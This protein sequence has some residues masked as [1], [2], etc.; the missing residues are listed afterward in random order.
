MKIIVAD[1]GPLIIFAKTIGL[2]I[3]KSVAHE[4][5]VPA[6][7]AAE[8]T[9]DMKKEGALR[10]ATAIREGLLTVVDDPDV[11]ALSG[12]LS[13]IDPGETMAIA[14]AKSLGCRVLLD[15]RRA[16]GIAKH[17]DV[18]AIGSVGILLLAKKAGAIDK[19]GP[20]LEAWRAN[21]YYLSDNLVR[22]ALELA[23]EPLV[24]KKSQ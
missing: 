5:L 7:V 16:R 1:S 24:A 14:L 6:T 13:L 17:L 23:A 2:E 9:V 11:S 20:T 4:V 21:S 12:T 3:I 19:I 22:K 8:S 10:I 18:Q 15:D